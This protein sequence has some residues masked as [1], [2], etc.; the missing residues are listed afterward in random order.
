[1][2][3]AANG[4]WTTRPPQAS[5][6]LHPL[7]DTFSRQG[8]AKLAGIFSGIVM[9]IYWIPL[10]YMDET[11]FPGMWAV[12]LFNLASLVLL[13]PY[14][15]KQWAQLVPGRK[16][17][18]VIAF[19]TGLAYVCYT[20]A[21]LYT[22]VIRALVFYYLMPVWGFFFAR[23]FIG[24]RITPVRWFSIL[25]GIGGLLVICG[26]D[27][28]IPV[29]SKAGDW[30]A[31]SGG[32]IWAG[33]ALA[34]LT[35]KQDTV[36]YTVTFLFWATLCSMVFALAASGSGELAPPQWEHL[37]GTLAWLVPFALLV[38]IPGAFVTLYA[39]SQ[40]NPGIVGLL[41]MTEISVGTL[42]AALLAD[43]P[44]GAKEI[45]GVLL[46]TLAG[47]AEPLFQLRREKPRFP[48]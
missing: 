4:I 11:G 30:L 2:P 26:L 19:I 9:G 15:L 29:P 35:D 31:L 40:L 7:F 18:H 22:E 17:M 34:I 46:I 5:F 8:W 24:E 14:I 44:F 37:G 41:F 3:V 27:E 12:F 48:N 47:V 10:R 6:S 1:M 32:I 23:I 42:T 45:A 21:F 13:A 36:N 16:R 25:L 43:E 38:I 20:G 33:A 39:P 28:G